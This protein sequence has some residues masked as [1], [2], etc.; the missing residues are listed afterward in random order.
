MTTDR[1]VRDGHEVVTDVP[2]DQEVR[3]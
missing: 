1:A 2:V 3:P